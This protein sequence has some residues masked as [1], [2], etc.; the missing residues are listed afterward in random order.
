MRRQAVSLSLP[1]GASA[2]GNV[3]AGKGGLDFQ[4]Q[5]VLSQLTAPPLGRGSS[6]V[7]PTPSPPPVS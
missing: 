4:H 1:L 3:G 2:S 6:L 7:V 5:R